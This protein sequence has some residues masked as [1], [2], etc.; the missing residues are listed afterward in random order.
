MGVCVSGWVSESVGPFLGSGQITNNLI[1]L[2]LIE[3]IQLCVKIY[4]L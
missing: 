4:D 1:K 3:I 2:G